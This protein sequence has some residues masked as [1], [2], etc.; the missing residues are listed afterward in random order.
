MLKKEFDNLNSNLINT[1]FITVLI[2]A[3]GSFI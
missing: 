2:D 1:N 3:E